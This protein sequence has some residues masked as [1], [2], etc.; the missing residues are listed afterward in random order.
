M[1]DVWSLLSCRAALFSCPDCAA[2]QQARALVF[3]AGFWHNALSVVAPLAVIAI[4]VQRFLRHLDR[5][6]DA[7]D[8]DAR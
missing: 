7:E 5:G 3:S 4:A 2:G 1:H 6:Q 8:R